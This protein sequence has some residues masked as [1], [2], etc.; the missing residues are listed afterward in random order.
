MTYSSATGDANGLA[1]LRVFSLGRSL[2]ASVV[3]A[4]LA[5]LGADVVHVVQPDKPL[6]GERK[7]LA[8]GHRLLPLRLEQETGRL[9]ARDWARAADVL[10]TD[11]EAGNPEPR[12]PRWESFQAE[13]PR[14]VG[15]SL[16][17]FPTDSGPLSLANGE[18]TLSAAQG[19][20]TRP[21]P[22]SAAYFPF[23]VLSVTA[24]LM[25]VA[26]L[27]AAR[28]SADREGT[29][30]RVAVSSKEVAP[31]LLEL[32]HLLS[33]GPVAFGNALR[34]ASSPFVGVYRCRS[35]WLYLHAGLI[36]H[37]ARL[38]HALGAV[39]P[40][41]A[42]ELGASLSEAFEADPLLPRTSRAA[43]R[44]SRILASAFR[45]QPAD[46]W[47]A[48]LG[49]AQV[50]A[51]RV[52]SR[53][54]FARSREG[55]QSGTYCGPASAPALGAL[56]QRDCAPRV[57]WQP[58]EPSQLAQESPPDWSQRPEPPERGPA[59]VARPCLEGVRVL[60]LSR[61]IA[62]PSAGRTLAWLGA[63]VLKVEDPLASPAFASAFRVL[64]DRGKEVEARDL[65]TEQGRTDFWKRV[66][67]FQP[68]VVLTNY[69]P[70]AAHRLGLDARALARR[71]PSALLVRVSSYGSDGPLAN[72]PGW[73]QTA[74]AVSGI[75]WALGQGTRPKLLPLPACDL[76]TGLVA[77][78]GALLGLWR[79]ERGLETPPLEAALVRTAS[80]LQCRELALSPEK[81]RFDAHGETPL[82][83]FYRCRRGRL[84]VA[85]G[86]NPFSYGALLSRLGATPASEV[87]PEKVQQALARALKRRSAQTWYRRLRPVAV[88]KN[89][90]ATS[91][92]A[93]ALP[94]S[95]RRVL[96]DSQRCRRS[97]LQALRYPRYGRVRHATLPV[98]LSRSPLA[99]LGP[100]HLSN[101]GPPARTA[102]RRLRRT[103]EARLRQLRFAPRALRNL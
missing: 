59:G 76:G 13:N 34:W 49:K 28:V 66:D 97:L 98:Q 1:G 78:I 46:F 63:R 26:G 5:D 102:G 21:G 94:R 52:R 48:H 12:L 3:T 69:R 82:P 72:S 84:M 64:F 44:A 99:S 93:V 70:D 25:A 10:L 35:G 11:D 60:D 54:E 7:L 85:A 9:R 20:Y 37:A 56:L 77:A 73:E 4:V 31:T 40:Q 67:E 42:T 101:E 18:A 17:G 6:E 36:A 16:L 71:L 47:E 53:A 29:G 23:P 32:T 96:R 62:G 91:V 95:T 14:L 87:S 80:W 8:R 55:R 38:V 100:T 41:Q 74:Q 61:I 103:L 65:R 68:D 43:G 88:A 2:A 19:L 90:P 30:Q 83:R 24:A 57:D 45:S 39:C 75:Q 33:S 79:R 92:A 86:P 27:L 89:R 58:R 22:L 81:L 15:V 50:S 51:A